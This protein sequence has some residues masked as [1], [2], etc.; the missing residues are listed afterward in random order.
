MLRFLEI[1]SEFEGVD[2]IPALMGGQ[3]EHLVLENLTRVIGSQ[4]VSHHPEVK[5]LPGLLRDSP[6]LKSIQLVDC[7]LSE[8]ASNIDR[9]ESIVL[10]NLQSLKLSECDDGLVLFLYETIATPACS[11]LVLETR[12]QLSPGAHRVVAQRMA[13]NFMPKE[14]KSHH[15]SL[16]IDAF[17]VIRTRTPSVYSRYDWSYS[18]DG[19]CYGLTAVFTHMSGEVKLALESVFL[20]QEAGAP[21]VL[22]LLHDNVPHL[23]E[24]GLECRGRRGLWDP[25]AHPSSDLSP[26]VENESIFPHLTRF[27]ILATK[28]QANFQ[29]SQAIRILSAR[30]TRRLSTFG[31]ETKNHTPLPLATLV[32]GRIDVPEYFKQKIRLEGVGI[33][34]DPW[35]TSDE[36]GG[37]EE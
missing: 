16:I 36:A 33:E 30:W 37:D 25:R 22:T 17:S 6:N 5:F 13:D 23:S 4:H 24:I 34:C 12:R 29:I 26:L 2:T 19:E 31:R 21:E 20:L 8:L 27:A 7:K 11:H 14:G 1:H 3:L 28:E 10:Q 18:D 15:K 35:L 9:S 32:L